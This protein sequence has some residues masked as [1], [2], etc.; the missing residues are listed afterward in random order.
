MWVVKKVGSLIRAGKKGNH[1]IGKK[2]S[3]SSP[4][5]RQKQKQGEKLLDPTIIDQAADMAEEEK[6]KKEAIEKE[7]EKEPPP[8]KPLPGDCCGSGCVRCVWDIYYEDLE[9]YNNRQRERE[10]KEDLLLLGKDDSSK[11]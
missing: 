9:D 1:G 8:E 11:P 3:S 7:E 10:K 2:L 5:L 6:R 4:P